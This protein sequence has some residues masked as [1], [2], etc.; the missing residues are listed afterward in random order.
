MKLLTFN[1]HG[2][3]DDNKSKRQEF[4]N[5]KSITH[6]KKSTTWIFK[7]KKFHA[8]Y[9]ITVLR[10]H[11]CFHSI[12]KIHDSYILSKEF[13]SSSFSIYKNKM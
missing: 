5:F 9:K 13:Q 11:A 8:A 2:S 10:M 1:F 4:Q 3:I 7:M 6:I 12:H